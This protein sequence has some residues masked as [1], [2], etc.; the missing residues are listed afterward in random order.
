MIHLTLIFFLL[1]LNI[2]GIE[3]VG[4]DIV[5]ILAALTLFSLFI[6]CYEW[7]RI[8]EKT[9][10]YIYLI[11]QTMQDILAFIVLFIASLFLFGFPTL[12]LNFYSFMDTDLYPRL[13]GFGLL[14]SL[15]NQYYL[16]LG[17]FHTD[18]YTKHPHSPIVFI[19]FICATLFTQITMLNMLIAIM[20]DTFERVTENSVGIKR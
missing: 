3:E 19:L 12:M 20:G 10:F 15:M 8:F 17:E 9:A 2:W 11:A 4:L 14:D 18:N 1:L 5:S 13:S 6:K 16:S 7:L